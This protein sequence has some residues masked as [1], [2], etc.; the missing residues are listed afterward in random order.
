MPATSYWI[1]LHETS[2]DT[3]LPALK[4]VL[5]SAFSSALTFCCSTASL[6]GTG[7]F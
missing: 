6:Q 1:L 7:L 3:L 4:I 2:T 5:V